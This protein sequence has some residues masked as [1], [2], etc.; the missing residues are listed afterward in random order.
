MTKTASFGILVIGSYLKFGIWNL[1]LILLFSL[2]GKSFIN[3]HHGDIVF[4][5]IE[6]VAG[7]AD[8][9]ISCAIQ[10]NISF[11]FWTSQNLQKLFTDRH[12][13]SPLLYKKKSLWFYG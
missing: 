10:K 12:L 2:I 3:Q 8:Q 5:R 13:H 7:F 1:V 11:T 4:N 9:A 6:Q